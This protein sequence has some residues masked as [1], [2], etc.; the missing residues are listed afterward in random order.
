MRGLLPSGGAL[1]EDLAY[2]KIYVCACVRVTSRWACNVFIS[3]DVYIRSDM[4]YV[5]VHIGWECRRCEKWVDMQPRKWE[6]A[7]E[8][9]WWWWCSACRKDGKV[10]EAAGA[11]SKKQK[12]AEK[13]AARCHKISFGA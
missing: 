10:G 13:L 11:K 12:E 9:A 5:Y 4:S 1:I 8:P 2:G 6:G 3:C 7:D